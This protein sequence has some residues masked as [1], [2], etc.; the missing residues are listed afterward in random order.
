MSRETG[1]IAERRKSRIVRRLVSVSKR[2]FGSFLHFQ[3]SSDFEK[4]LRVFYEDVPALPLLPKRTVKPPT[5]PKPHALGL[6][7]INF[8]SWLHDLICK[9]FA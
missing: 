2:T 7:I 9:I 6:S 8:S 1:S 3:P 5:T 4:R